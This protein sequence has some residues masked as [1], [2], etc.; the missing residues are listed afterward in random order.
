MAVYVQSGSAVPA[1]E[2]QLADGMIIVPV[3]DTNKP[4]TKVCKKCKQRK[5]TYEF[6]RNRGKLDG[7]ESSCVLCKRGST[8]KDLATRRSSDAYIQKLRQAAI[9]R[10]ATK[11]S[12]LLLQNRKS[13]TH[14]QLVLTPANEKETEMAHH[15][16]AALLRECSMVILST[17]KDEA[18]PAVAHK[19]DIKVCVRL[20]TPQ[21]KLA[22]IE[23][24]EK[25]LGS[26]VTVKDITPV[27]GWNGCN[28]SNN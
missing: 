15:V 21:T 8:R 25:A 28:L 4:S 19:K 9:R 18:S 26:N 1:T 2:M 3:T 13:A 16:R 6:Y 22:V 11:R 14:W 7:F 12:E 10:H 5:S 23:M 17:D 20:K 27:L 24:I